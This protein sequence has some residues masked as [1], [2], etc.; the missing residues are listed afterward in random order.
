M[1]GQTLMCHRSECLCVCVCPIPLKL[2]VLFIGLLLE[3]RWIIRC[4]TR[5]PGTHSTF[6]P[7]LAANAGPICYNCIVSISDSDAVGVENSELKSTPGTQQVAITDVQF[8]RISFSSCSIG[9]FLH[10]NFVTRFVTLYARHHSFGIK[11]S[12]KFYPWQESKKAPIPPQAGLGVLANFFCCLECERIRF[13]VAVVH[14]KRQRRGSCREE[15][16]LQS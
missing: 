6:Q 16:Q 9:T 1:S 2:M 10:V 14:R 11:P 13:L 8:Y 12:L 4:F 7:Q 5:A 15:R 3:W